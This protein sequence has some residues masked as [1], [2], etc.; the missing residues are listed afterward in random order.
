M[1]S[2]NFDDVKTT[3]GALKKQN[4][5]GEPNEKSVK[6]TKPD[7]YVLSI[8][9]EGNI[10]RAFQNDSLDLA[11]DFGQAFLFVTKNKLV[12]D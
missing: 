6:I 9:F 1:G 12:T 7:R 2:F 8:G 3:I 10:E 11:S 4:D 5:S